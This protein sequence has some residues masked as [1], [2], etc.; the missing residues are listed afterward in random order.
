MYSMRILRLS[1]AKEDFLKVQDKEARSVA[2]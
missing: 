1:G 2:F